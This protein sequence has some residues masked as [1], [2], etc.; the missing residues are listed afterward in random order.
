V[1]HLLG[2]SPQ[3][4]NPLAVGVMICFL[5]ILLVVFAIL[6]QFL[7]LYVRATVSG[8]QISMLELI[9]MRLRKVNAIEIVNARIMTRR[10]G[11]GVTTAEMEAHVLAGGDL[12]QVVTALIAA[13]KLGK[14]IPWKLA[15]AAD[16]AGRDVVQYVQ[17]G[18]WQRGQDWKTAAPMR[19]SRHTTAAADAALMGS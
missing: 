11:L 2:Q 12:K 7:G 1:N 5:I 13:K 15:T 19:P 6:F 9:G 14:D 18:A 17:S 10:E 16:L 8:V 3:T 4:F